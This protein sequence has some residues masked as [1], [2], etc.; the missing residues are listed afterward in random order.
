MRNSFVRA[1]AA[2][3]LIAPLASAC[4][5]PAVSAQ[6]SQETTSAQPPKPVPETLPDVVARVNGEDV[7]KAQFEK[8]IGNL[9]TRCT[10][11]RSTKS[12]T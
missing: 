10:G 12:A 3:V 5:K 6:S 1:V 9:A 8:F 11:T 4:R 2:L 7:T